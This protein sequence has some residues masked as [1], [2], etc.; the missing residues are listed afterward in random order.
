M[1]L[2]RLY[3][4]VSDIVSDNSSLEDY[5]FFD[6]KELWDLSLSVVVLKQV[7]EHSR[8][9]RTLLGSLG[10]VG[11]AGMAGAASALVSA[12]VLQTNTV[13]QVSL[14]GIAAASG[15]A[16]LGICRLTFAGQTK[17]SEEKLAAFRDNSSVPFHVRSLS[18]T[19]WLLDRSRSE[20]EPLIDALS[21]IPDFSAIFHP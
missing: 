3:G 6:R 21:R 13:N 8:K 2:Q 18:Q 12:Q 15:I 1:E 17:A 19:S 11:L 9:I 5:D 16:Q 4:R 14:L 10:Y 7:I 20:G